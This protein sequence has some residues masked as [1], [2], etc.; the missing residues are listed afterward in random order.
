MKVEAMPCCHVAVECNGGHMLN[1]FSVECEACPVGEYQPVGL[2]MLCLS[3]DANY[4]TANTGSTLETDCKCRHQILVYFT[5]F[6]V[7]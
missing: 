3:C 2:Q 1:F 7:E 6:L 5:Q 4:S